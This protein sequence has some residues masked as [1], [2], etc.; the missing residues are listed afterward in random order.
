MYLSLNYIASAVNGRIRG[1]KVVCRDPEANYR[2]KWKNNRHT[3]TIYPHGDGDIRVNCFAGQDPIAK[4][5]WVR[6]QC[7][8][9]AW[10]P[11][12]KADPPFKVSNQFVG[13]TLR[14]CRDRKQ[15]TFEHFCLLANDLRPIDE[16]S[17]TWVRWYGS[18]F[19]I[20]EVEKAINLSLKHRR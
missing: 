8:L 9:P 5:D 10:K 19:G 18:E 1:N 11:K 17:K 14:V 6:Q 12:P 16:T 13:E 2:L 3:I 20:D 7:G 15:A 4:K